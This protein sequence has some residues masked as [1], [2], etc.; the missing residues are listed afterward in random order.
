[1][2]QGQNR[3]GSDPDIARATPREVP[4]GVFLL[5]GGRSTEHDASLHSYFAVL[6]DLESRAVPPIAG[7]YYVDRDGRVHRCTE[8]P[9]PDSESSLLGAEQISRTAL[10]EDLAAPNRHVFSLLHGNEGEDGAWQGIAEVFDI[11]GSFGPVFAAALS[12][13]KWAQG[14][15]ALHLCAGEISLAPTWRIT[16]NSPSDACSAIADALHGRPCIVK[17][18][19][20]GASLLATFHASIDEE[21]LRSEVARLFSYDSEVLVQEH[22]PGVEYTVGVLSRGGIASAL[23]VVEITPREAFLSFG[24][25]HSDERAAA[26]VVNPDTPLAGRLKSLATRIFSSVDF[27]TMCR[28]DFIVTPSGQI[29]FLE[30][31]SIPGLAKGSLYPKMLQAEGLDLADLVAASIE[32]AGRI[33]VRNKALP[34]EIRPPEST[35]TP[36][37]VAGG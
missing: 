7:V 27:L 17:P 32:E 3:L 9:W 8:A 10:L 26:A 12:M 19:R 30:A 4:V 16:R 28:F 36:R 14:V 13:N 22:V 21:A 34:Y 29:Y 31:N 15:I 33:P 23:P 11:R 35:T 5:L 24:D 37:E 18:N 25:K 20:M 2:T 6:H 1:M